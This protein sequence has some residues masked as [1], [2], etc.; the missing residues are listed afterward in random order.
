MDITPIIL[1]AKLSLVTTSVLVAAALPVAYWLA[2]CRFPGKSLV[3][4]FFNLPLV[5]PPTVLGFYLL[6]AMGPQGFLGLFWEATFGSR[7]VFTFSGLVI[8]SMIYSLPFALQPLKTAFEKIDP[9]LL[10]SAY[11]LGC[12]KT[13]SF[14]KVILPNSFGG[15]AAAAVLVFA[16]TMGEFGV[17]LMV[18][19]SIPGKTKVASIAIFE[20][21]ESLQ[22]KEAALIS[23]ILIPMSYAVLLIVNR[24][25][26]R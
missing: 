20:Y 10:E 4:A 23:M 9:R 12:S 2:F 18:G 16:H 24:L 11:V 7:L 1:S 3:E 13:A 22:Y 14:F 25:S 8:A 19:G 17:I 26:R 15:V 6:V 21:V 5:L